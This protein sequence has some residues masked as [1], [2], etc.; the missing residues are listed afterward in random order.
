MDLHNNDVGITLYENNPG[1][2]DSSY[3]YICN[4]MKQRGALD[5]TD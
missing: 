4:G 5:V 2:S 3:L 1:L